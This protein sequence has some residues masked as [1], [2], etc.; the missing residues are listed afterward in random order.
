MRAVYG[1]AARY[2]FHEQVTVAGEKV[3]KS[4]SVAVSPPNFPAKLQVNH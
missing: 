1:R 4:L 2:F 3:T